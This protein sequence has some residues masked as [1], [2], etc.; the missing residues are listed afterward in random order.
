MNQEPVTITYS[1]EDILLRLERN[2][3]Q[4][5]EQLEQKFDQRF[6]QIDRRFEQLEQKFDKKFEQLE[7]KLDKKFDELVKKIERLQEDVNDL[8]AKHA[9]LTEKIGGLDKRIENQEF[10]NRGVV[11]GLILAFLAGL[12]KLFGIIG[13]PNL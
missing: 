11:V 8:R 5:F 13:N 12:A 2:I 6:E 9:G 7:Q 10:V 3:N 1:I 4:R